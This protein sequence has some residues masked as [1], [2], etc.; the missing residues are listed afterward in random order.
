VPY[1][2][3]LRPATRCIRY[4]LA[5]PPGLIAEALPHG[6]WV[7]PI[8]TGDAALPAE[9]DLPE[10][11]AGLS[12]RQHVPLRRRYTSHDLA[13]LLPPTHRTAPY[14][15]GCPVKRPHNALTDCG[16]DDVPLMFRQLGTTATTTWDLNR[17]HR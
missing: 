8:L 4:W 2:V 16:S 10:D 3:G 5:A 17:T 14:Q 12:R 6:L 1:R 13:G 7:I 11:I 9:A 15:Q